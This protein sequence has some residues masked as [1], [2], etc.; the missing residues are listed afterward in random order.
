M[1]DQFPE[2]KLNEEDE[3]ATQIAL[4]IDSGNVILMFT[5]AIT[6]IGGEP[7]WA[8]QLADAIKAKAQ[9]VR[10]LTKD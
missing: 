4:G 6:W 7:D 10:E 2:G 8:D 5:K 3:G 9:E 1:S